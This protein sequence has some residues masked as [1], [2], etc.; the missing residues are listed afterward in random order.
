[1][2][3]AIKCPCGHPACTAWMVDPQAAIQGISF[4]E[5]EARAV[6]ELLTKMQEAAWHVKTF[7]VH[8]PVMEADRR[9]HE[10]ELRGR[11]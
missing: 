7:C 10:E 9:R 2:A 4:T 8:A 11:T 5:R 6:A 3:K 1:M